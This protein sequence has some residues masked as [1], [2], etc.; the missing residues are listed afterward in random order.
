MNLYLYL[1]VCFFSRFFS[2]LKAGSNLSNYEIIIYKFFLEMIVI[3]LQNPHLLKA[4]L[5]VLLKLL[6]EGNR[7][8]LAAKGG[9][10]LTLVNQ[11][12]A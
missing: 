6:K 2:N 9:G 11:P 8:V 10:M 5:A 12:V 7:S 3:N 4:L 1:H